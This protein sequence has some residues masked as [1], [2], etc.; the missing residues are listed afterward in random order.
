MRGAESRNVALVP[1]TRGSNHEP[2]SAP[3]SKSNAPDLPD[4][5]RTRIHDFTPPVS[6]RATTSTSYS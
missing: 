1:Y 4:S 3:L 2:V 5:A 6:D